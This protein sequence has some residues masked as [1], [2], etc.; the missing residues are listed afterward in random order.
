MRLFDWKLV[1]I[2]K[3]EID[4]DVITKRC[5]KN[6][7][8]NNP[9]DISVEDAK[10]LFKIGK[11]MAD[12]ELKKSQV[13]YREWLNRH[14]CNVI[15]S[16]SIFATTHKTDGMFDYITI[17]FLNELKDY[18]EQKGFTVDIMGDSDSQYLRICG[19][20]DEEGSDD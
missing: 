11:R 9:S 4:P 7:V 2:R 17:E 13:N 8:V 20:A 6:K 16:G 14:I 12:D 3:A 10:Q 5:I 1:K 15:E 19:W 18:Y